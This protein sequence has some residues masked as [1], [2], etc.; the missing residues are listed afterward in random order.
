MAGFIQRKRDPGINV[1]ADLLEVYA[2]YPQQNGIWINS[3][4]RTDLKNLKVK[5]RDE[6]KTLQDVKLNLRYINET[7]FLDIEENTSLSFS[8]LENRQG[9]FLKQGELY[10]TLEPSSKFDHVCIL[11]LHAIII[12]HQALVRIVCGKNTS[13]TVKEGTVKVYSVGSREILF[14]QTGQSTIIPQ[15]TLNIKNKAAG[16]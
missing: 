3:C 6:L 5:A 8:E 9:I 13:I 12:V 16:L 1:S 2:E 11:T 10:M 7:S 4:L 14:L 15:K